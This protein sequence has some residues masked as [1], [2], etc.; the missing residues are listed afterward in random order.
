MYHSASFEHTADV[1]GLAA[2]LELD[3]DLFRLCIC[4]HYCLYSLVVS[5]V[6]KTRVECRNAFFYRLYREYLTD[7]AGGSYDHIGGGDAHSFCRELTHFLCFF[8]TVGVAGVRVDRVDNNA[9][10]I[11]VREVFLCYCERSAL[12]L[13]GRVNSSR[14]RALIG[15]YHREVVLLVCRERVVCSLRLFLCFGERLMRETAVYTVCFPAFC[16]AN[17]AVNE[18][19]YFRAYE[20]YTELVD[21]L[22][23]LIGYFYIICCI[24]FTHNCIS[25]QVR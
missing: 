17:A 24:Y 7:N 22:L 11:A 3:S 25:F 6:R 20:P 2:D 9:L 4:S 16:R 21:K 14:C 23:K 10:C 5:G 8:D 13:V 1:A 15:H 12:D 19:V 18:I